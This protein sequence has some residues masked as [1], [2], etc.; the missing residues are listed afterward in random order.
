M[1][2]TILRQDLN[3]N[4]WCVQGSAS[5]DMTTLRAGAP[6]PTSLPTPVELDLRDDSGI[7]SDFFETPYFIVSDVMRSALSSAGVD[8]I[9]YYET[10]LRHPTTR[11]AHGGFW[12][13]NIT[14]IVSCVDEAKSKYKMLS[15]GRK[16]LRHFE[17]DESKTHGLSLFRLRESTRL[18]LIADRVKETLQSAGL[19]GLYFQ[20]TSQ[21]DGKPA[22]SYWDD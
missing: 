17:I 10:V 22:S 4:V 13:G 20:E 15:G 6:L 7:P 2:Y 9:D 19:A 16:L 1:P 14:G 18:V 5:L 3:P 11:A 21:F 12:L 8:N